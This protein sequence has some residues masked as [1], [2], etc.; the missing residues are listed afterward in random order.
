[1]KDERE[2]FYAEAPIRVTS[3][4]APHLQTARSI[5]EAIDRWL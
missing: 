4:D 5:I 1:L 2:R 3:D